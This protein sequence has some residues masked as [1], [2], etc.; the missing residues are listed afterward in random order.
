MPSDKVTLLVTEEEID[1]LELRN[2]LD[3]VLEFV[4]LKVRRAD[5]IVRV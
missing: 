2:K 1:D 5:R 4:A 3:L